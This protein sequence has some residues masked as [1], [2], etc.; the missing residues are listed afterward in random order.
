[1]SEAAIGRQS[2]EAYEA[3]LERLSPDVRAAVVS[4]V[5][6]GLSYR[7]IATVL[8]KPSPDAARMAVTRA[9]VRM[10]EEIEAGPAPRADSGTN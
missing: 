5:E 4:R 10:A 9:L 7:E 8:D 2:L 6:L 1:M 3:G